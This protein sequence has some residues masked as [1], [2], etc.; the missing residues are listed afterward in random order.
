MQQ[1]NAKEKEK[2]EMRLEEKPSRSK[3]VAHTQESE[4]EE[5]RW[6]KKKRQQE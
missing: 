2:H 5:R 4:G 6:R 3:T 1:I